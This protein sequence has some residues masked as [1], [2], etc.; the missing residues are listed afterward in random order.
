ML[1]RQASWPCFERYIGIII[2]CNCLLTSCIINV[3]DAK[4]A[5]SPNLLSSFST[6]TSSASKYIQIKPWFSCSHHSRWRELVIDHASALKNDSSDSC[7]STSDPEAYLLE[8]T[9]RFNLLSQVMSNWCSVRN[10][11][12]SWSYSD[13]CSLRN[14]HSMQLIVM[15]CTLWDNAKHHPGVISNFSYCKI[16]C[17]RR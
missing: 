10:R 4:Y 13:R 5:W 2:V 8:S 7:Q 16:K 14:H 9:R 17:I 6:V 12:A 15:I 3:W 11:E 1:I